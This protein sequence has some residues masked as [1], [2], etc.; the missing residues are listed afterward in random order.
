MS[1][2][3]TVINE[4]WVFPNAIFKYV[5]SSFF[6]DIIEDFILEAKN[7]K[8]SNPNDEVYI[9]FS[10]TSD[11]SQVIEFVDVFNF[12]DNFSIEKL[13]A[14]GNVLKL[15]FKNINTKSIGEL[16]Y[17]IS[18]AVKAK[19]GTNTY[20]AIETVNI[21]GKVIISQDAGTITEELESVNFANDDLLITAISDSAYLLQINLEVNYLGVINKIS[22]EELF[23]NGTL[24]C[25]LKGILQPYIYITDEQIEDFFTNFKTNLEPAIVKIN[26]RFL[27]ERFEEIGNLYHVDPFKFF[28][29][30]KE[31]LP[32]E[33][34]EILRSMNYNTF[35]PLAYEFKNQNIDITFNEI[36]KTIDKQALSSNGKIL[37][38]LFSQ[39]SNSFNKNK[40]ASFSSGFS[41]GFATE[42]AYTNAKSI[43]QYKPGFTN[44]IESYYKVTGY[45]FPWQKQAFNLIWLDENNFFR[46]LPLTGVKTGEKQI[47]NYLNENAE[48]PKFYKAGVT[49]KDVKKVNTGFILNSETDLVI[50]LQKAK[51]AW[52][53]EDDPSKRIFCV[54]VNS[55]I[56][57]EDTDREMIQYDLDLE[58]YE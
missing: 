27:N 29:G 15:K 24:T 46:S 14:Y 36:K 30:K 54:A 18:I 34:E 23:V 28:A 49:V 25:N 55:K 12:T 48:N 56:A 21:P 2:S 50:N 39:R 37:Q 42:E 1:Y 13:Y 53:F 35:L 58:F 44:E 7:Y 9:Q 31:N 17:N 57:D 4:N 19:T 43:Y 32:K 11:Q 3:L 33:D 10:Y 38:L 45:N 41:S 51:K 16:N 40:A 52:F 22:L 8:K 47:K 26:Y 5:K 20:T 6:T